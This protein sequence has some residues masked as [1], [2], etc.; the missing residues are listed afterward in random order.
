MI[1]LWIIV[2]YDGDRADRVV[3]R[4]RK[5]RPA[6]SLPTSGRPAG[7][8]NAL[9]RDNGPRESTSSKYGRDF[10]DE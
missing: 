3:I 8:P 7:P 2:E 9:C 6:M 4:D 10:D 5:S 1:P